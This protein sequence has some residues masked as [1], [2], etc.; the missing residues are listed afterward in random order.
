MVT[1]RKAIVNSAKDFVAAFNIEK[2]SVDVFEMSNS[3]I[4]KINKKLKVDEVFDKAPNISG[5]TSAHQLHTIGG[6]IFDFVTSSDGYEK[7]KI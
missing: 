3:E 5:I 6:K 2:S 7:L 4:E 1:T